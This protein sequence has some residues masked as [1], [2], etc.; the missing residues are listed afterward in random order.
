MFIKLLVLT[1]PF[2]GLGWESE[3]LLSVERGIL[4]KLDYCTGI[5]IC[6]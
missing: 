2:T 1:K 3:F 6:T 4:F 5:K